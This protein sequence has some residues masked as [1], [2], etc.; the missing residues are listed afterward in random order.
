MDTYFFFHCNHTL[1]RLK[2]EQQ[3]HLLCRPPLE[4]LPCVVWHTGSWHEQGTWTCLVRASIIKEKC[5][6]FNYKVII[7]IRTFY[8]KA[9]LDFQKAFRSMLVTREHFVFIW[10]EAHIFMFW[11]FL[12]VQKE[13]VHTKLFCGF[14]FFQP[15]EV[16]K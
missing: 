5:D 4:L 11:T 14:T 3:T 6:T 15:F 9:N 16:N 7:R 10:T 13:N 1:S 2:E 8:W 12:D